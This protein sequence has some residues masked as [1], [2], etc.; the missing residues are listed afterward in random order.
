V[1]GLLGGFVRRNWTTAGVALSLCLL[2]GAC[3]GDGDENS[4]TFEPGDATSS[5]A[6]SGT[7]SPSASR[8]TFA[9]PPHFKLTF[10]YK[11]T[12]DPKKDAILADLRTFW[13]A[14]YYAAVDPREKREQWVAYTT[15]SATGFH[16]NTLAGFKKN[17]RGV[18]GE[19]SSYRARVTQFTT[20]SANVVECRDLRRYF[21]RELSTGKRVGTSNPGDYLQISSNLVS[22]KKGTWQVKVQVWKRGVA[23]CKP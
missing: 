7:P 4:E 10:D 22:N 3:G 13:E 17:N 19:V 14:F 2:L 18:E 23:E 5:A 21:G 6:A 8:P 1:I 15:G 11:P 20:K 9:F 16:A 12:G